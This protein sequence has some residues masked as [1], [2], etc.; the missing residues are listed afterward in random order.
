MASAWDRTLNQLAETGSSGATLTKS[1]PRQRYAPGTTSLPDNLWG[2][3]VPGWDGNIVAEFGFRT[4]VDFGK[5][6]SNLR[7]TAS[8]LASVAPCRHHD[9]EIG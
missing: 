6:T 2:S 5:E 3:G 1:G 4:I 9:A 7:K 8:P